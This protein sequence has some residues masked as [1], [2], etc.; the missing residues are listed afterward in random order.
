M[1]AFHTRDPVTALVMN[2]IAL[3]DNVK[4]TLECADEILSACRFHPMVFF[5]ARPEASRCQV[6]Q[7]VVNVGAALGGTDS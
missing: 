6:T 2:N 7:Y 1:R 4:M 5:T 3:P